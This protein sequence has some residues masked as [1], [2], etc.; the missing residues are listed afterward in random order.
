MAFN[1]GR[2]FLFK[3]TVNWRFLPEW[4][5]LSR[6]FHISLLACHLTVLLLFYLCKWTRYVVPCK[7]NTT[8]SWIEIYETNHFWTA[9]LR[10]WKWR[11]SSQLNNNT[12]GWKKNLKNFRHDRELKPDLCAD[13]M[14]CSIYWAN[15]ANWRAGHCEFV[16]Y[17]MD[18]IMSIEWQK[19]MFTFTTFSLTINI[20][21]A[22]IV[23]TNNIIIIN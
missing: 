13:R 16:T 6:Y 22:C 4:L 19:I 5:F 7:C 11:W 2:Q 8:F 1:L 23:K 21:E 10:I 17:P 14:Q 15:Q 12:S 18:E 9:H 20:L 3:W